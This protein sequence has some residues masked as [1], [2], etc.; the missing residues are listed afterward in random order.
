MKSWV[1]TMKAGPNGPATTIAQNAE[2]IRFVGSGGDAVSVVQ[3]KPGDQV[4]GYVEEREG[5]SGTK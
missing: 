1:W 3:L 2:T 5:I 4:L